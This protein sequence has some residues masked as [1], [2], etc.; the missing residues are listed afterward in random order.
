VAAEAPDATVR[1]A[2][3]GEA[4]LTPPGAFSSLVAGAIE[5]VAGITPELSTTGGTSDARF[6]S[7]LAPT[8]EFGLVNATM[9]KLDEAVAVPDLLALTDIYAAIIRRACAAG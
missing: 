3:S 7:K 4:F 9:H 6:L 8:V 5:D 2:I 1:A